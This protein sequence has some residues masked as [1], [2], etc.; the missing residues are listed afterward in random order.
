MKRDESELFALWCEAVWML[1]AH[2]QMPW[3]EVFEYDGR[4]I[5]APMRVP[6]PFS[7]RMRPWL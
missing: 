7:L 5:L 2:N 1:P 6:T 4:E 3:I